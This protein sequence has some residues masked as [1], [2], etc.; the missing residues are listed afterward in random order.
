[1][2]DIIEY[3]ESKGCSYLSSEG[4]GVFYKAPNGK[5]LYASEVSIVNH[6]KEENN[7]EEV[8]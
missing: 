8:N 1:M 5:V 2:D 4:A 3:L 7:Y 6:M